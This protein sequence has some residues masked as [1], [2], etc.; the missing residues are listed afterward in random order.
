MDNIINGIITFLINRTLTVSIL[1]III[2]FVKK[3]LY[4]KLNARINFLIWYIVIFYAISV[5]I[6]S[7]SIELNL[8]R[9]TEYF[10]E[11][12]TKEQTIYKTNYFEE[13]N[14]N[15]NSNE[16]KQIDFINN[17]IQQNKNKFHQFTISKKVMMYLFAL[18]IF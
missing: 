11:N 8:N 3:L 17:E 2:L 7:F 14:N 13:N 18:W 1:I 15:T 16:E 12:F 10:K 6:P 5:C 4:N 9:I